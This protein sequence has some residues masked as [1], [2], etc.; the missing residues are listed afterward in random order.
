MCEILFSVRTPGFSAGSETG[1]GATD[2]A[3]QAYPLPEPSL[4]SWE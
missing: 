1:Y 3:C 2:L 4:A